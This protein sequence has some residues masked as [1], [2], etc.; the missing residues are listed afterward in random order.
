MA[1]CTLLLSVAS[2][3]ASAQDAAV[4]ALEPM[5]RS[6][7]TWTCDARTLGAGGHPFTATL[8]LRKDF[9][10]HAILERYEELGTDAHP[11]PTRL[12]TIWSYD[13]RTRR[14][15]RNGADMAGNRIADSTTPMADGTFTWEHEDYRMPV[16]A[17]SDT[18]FSFALSVP[19]EDKW[20]TIAEGICTRQ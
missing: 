4:R 16:V 12:W 2:T 15:M 13:P 9:D 7:G 10:G 14:V 17:L 3:T 11:Q 19:R 5:M 8:E 1:S 18:R 6:V 20:V